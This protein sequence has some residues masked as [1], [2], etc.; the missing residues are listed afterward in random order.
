VKY[1]FHELAVFRAKTSGSTNILI[2]IVL[3]IFNESI[4]KLLMFRKCSKLYKFSLII[5]NHRYKKIQSGFVE[6]NL[7][8]V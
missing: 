8:F 1:L 7:K 3:G 4:Q 2:E 5:V 6:K